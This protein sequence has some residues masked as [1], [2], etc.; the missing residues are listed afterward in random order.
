MINQSLPKCAYCGNQVAAGQHHLLPRGSNPDKID[1]KENLVGLCFNCHRRAHN[2]Q[3]FLKALQEIFYLWR[4]AHL[5]L[6]MRAQASI[7][8]LSDGK[9]IEYFTPAMADNYLQ[10][11]GAGYSHYSERMGELENL[12]AEF[13][14]KHKDDEISN[15]ELELNWRCTPEGKEMNVIKHKLKAL[16]KIQSNLRARLKRL[17]TEY[18]SSR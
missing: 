6:F 8:A 7:S 10:L 5:D 2:D 16:E 18:F 14:S 1:E 11:A 9:D 13:F 17:E 3:S 4:P 12:F 15:R